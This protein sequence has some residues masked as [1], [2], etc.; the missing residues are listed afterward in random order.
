MRYQKFE[1]TTINSVDS[2][3]FRPGS[4]KVLFRIDF[5]VLVERIT[6]VLGT[7]ET[8]VEPIQLQVLKQ[9]MDDKDFTLG[10]TTNLFGKLIVRAKNN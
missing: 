5:Y 1:R 7:I 10:R 8:E 9:V 3:C 4:L 6:D 2:I